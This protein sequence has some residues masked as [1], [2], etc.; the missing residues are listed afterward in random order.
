MRKR[1]LTNTYL[2]MLC[3]EYAMLFQSG[4]TVNEGTAMMLDDET[5]SERKF[6]LQN[7]MTTLEKGNHLSEALKESGCF[8]SYMVTMVDIGEKTGR[9][10]ETLTS[11]S[12][13]YDRK[14]RL[15]SAVRNATLYPAI[16]LAMM[17]AVVLILVV[18]VLPIFNATF[19]RLGTQ[20]SPMAVRFMQFGNWLKGV[21][22]GIALVFGVLFVIAFLLWVIPELREGITK[23]F[24]NRMGN[25]GI[26]RKVASAHFVSGVTLGMASG[27][28]MEKALEM[29][30][31]ISGDVKAVKEQQEKCVQLI[32]KGT[33]LSTA[34]RDSGII[35]ARDSR[36]LAIGERSGMSDAVMSDIAKRSER[37]AQDEIN[38]IVARI[39]PTL[40]VITTAII[41]VILLSV[42]LPMMGIMTAIG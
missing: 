15:A 4:I 27:L 35:S 20:M 31:S 6:V 25:K 32:I 18:Q 42:M 33:A 37:E 1:Q 8:P 21:S 2:S 19:S 40:V 3:T 36:V 7:L 28:D 38:H 12:E 11:L 10:P 39:E 23:A 14:D 34:L 5:D 9:L 22:A 26:F 30:V 17:I 16:L 24:N 41:G 29:A 13:H